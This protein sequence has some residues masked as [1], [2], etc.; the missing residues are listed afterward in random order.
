MPVHYVQVVWATHESK[1]KQIREQVFVAELGIAQDVE[2]DGL[3][4]ASEHFLALNEAGQALGTVR[5]LKNGQIG[6][7]AVLPE[8]RRRGIGRQLLNVAAEHAGNT[9]HQRV[10][11]HA[12]PQADAFFRA[13][14]FRTANS[15]SSDPTEHID[16]E[17]A[18]P[19]RF[20]PPQR[21]GAPSLA[22]GRGMTIDEP[23]PYRLVQFDTEHECRAA[24]CDLL[25]GARRTVVVLSASLDPQLF[26]GDEC[27]ASVS[28]LARRS[29]HTRVLILVEET[30]TIADSGHALLELARRLPS[31]VLIRRL[32]GDREPPRNSYM[33]VDG[34]AV[35]MLPDRDVYV[36]WTNQHDRVEARRLADDFMWL[37]ERS[38]E[39]PELRLLS[40]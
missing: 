4:E 28:A 13:V 7:V 5:L 24:L 33:V 34:E 31:K 36:G 10:F 9:G 21:T 22:A 19:I 12:R 25:A 27:V 20:E 37:F 26:A 3:D 39:D 11:V 14:G 40:L 38:S 16:M 35:W 30:K 6:H 32:P 15:Q 8:H 29:R 17:L 23:R 2:V 1:L 18:L